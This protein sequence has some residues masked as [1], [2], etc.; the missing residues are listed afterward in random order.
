MEV[1]RG[2]I[3]LADLS[4]VVGSEQGGIRPVLIVQN[5]VGNKYSPTV[6]VVAITSKTFKTKIPTHVDFCAQD[7]GLTRNS[8]ILCEQMRTIDKMRLKLKLG[9]IEGH[10][11]KRINDALKVSLNI[12]WFFI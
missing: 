7:Y 1:E 5:N 11:L 6:I 10:I 3:Y 8:L 12:S 2:E 9:K 4:P